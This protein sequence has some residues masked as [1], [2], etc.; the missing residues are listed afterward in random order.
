MYSFMKE[1]KYIDP[2]KNYF[3]KSAIRLFVSCLILSATV[4]TACTDDDE[5]YIVSINK[6]TVNF[7]KDVTVS[8]FVVTSSGEWK[9]QGDK[10]ELQYG[11]N[12]AL[13]EWYMIDPVTGLKGAP[14]IIRLKE[15]IDK[16]K[17]YSSTLDVIGKHNRVTVNL[18]YT[19]QQTAQ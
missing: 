13:G 6:G 14:V 12:S 16:E 18:L 9:I 19:P 1:N 15:D 17:E 3:P 5:E 8:Q 4:I 11:T 7:S 10:L 2:M